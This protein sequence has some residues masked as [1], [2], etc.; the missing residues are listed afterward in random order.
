MFVGMRIQML[1]DID[2]IQAQEKRW[3]VLRSPEAQLILSDRPGRLMSITASPKIL[4]AADN[5]NGD[6]TP[7]ETYHVNRV[8]I[9]R[10]RNYVIVP[11]R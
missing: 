6:L 11:P 3:G 9:G 7:A 10:S 2:T 4:L 5:P 8:S 1:I